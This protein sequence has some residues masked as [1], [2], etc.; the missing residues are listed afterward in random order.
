MQKIKFTITGSV[1]IPD[2]DIP[3]YT[4]ENGVIDYEMMV[5]DNFELYGNGGYNIVSAE[6]D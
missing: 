1:E 6:V 5:A 4:Y 2:E 3:A